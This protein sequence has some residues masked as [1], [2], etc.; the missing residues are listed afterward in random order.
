MEEFEDPWLPVHQ[1]L[2]ETVGNEVVKEGVEQTQGVEEGEEAGVVGEFI[3]P[4]RLVDDAGGVLVIGQ[5]QEDA[6]EGQAVH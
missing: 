1:R 2:D 5:L 3:L 6:G 4:Y